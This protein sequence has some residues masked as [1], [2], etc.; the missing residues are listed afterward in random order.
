M[1]LLL[2]VFTQRNFVAVFLRQECPF[3]RKAAISRLWAP[4]GGIRGITYTVH[5][6]IRKGVVDLL[7]VIIELFCRCY[8]LR[9]Y[10]RKSIENCR[11][12]R[13]GVSLAQNSGSTPNNGCQ[14]TRHSPKSYD[15]LTGDW[16]TVLWRVDR[17][18]KR[19]AVTAV[20]S[21]PHVAVGVAVDSSALFNSPLTPPPRVAQKTQKCR[22]FEQ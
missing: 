16:K 21:W 6:L 9:S 2:T 3:R 8:R 14:S 5:R 4:V 20:T 13:N 22:T 7:L 10:E 15:E 1:R 11:V 19:R 17:R 12:R 18:L